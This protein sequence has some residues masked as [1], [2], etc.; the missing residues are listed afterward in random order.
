LKRMILAD[1]KMGRGFALM[2]PHGDLSEELLNLVPSSR[3]NDVLYFDPASANDPV[4]FNMLAKVPE[5]RRHLLVSGIVT[6]LKGIWGDSWGPR[7]QMILSQAL[8]ALTEVENVSL[9]SV[10]RMLVDDGY[11][12]WVVKQVRDVAVRQFW[13]REW[14]MWDP[15]FRAEAA[16]PVL[17]KLNALTLNPC[18]RLSLGQVR[19]AFDPRWLMDHGKIFIANLSR[20]RLGP[21]PS[22]LIGSLLVAAFGM[23]AMSRA[24]VPPEQRRDVT[25]YV[26]EF[27]TFSTD[28]F[29]PF[30]SEL[31]K[32]SAAMV[33]ACQHFSQIRLEVLDSVLG[34]VGTTISFRVG[35]R[36][37]QTLSRQFNNVFAPDAFTGLG[38][39]EIA[40]K[41]L[42]G[43]RQ[44]QPFLGRTLPDDHTL[45]GKGDSIRRHCCQRYGTPR[46]VVENKIERWMR[47]KELPDL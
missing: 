43:G 47:G 37:A 9:L 20:G 1:M 40:V 13:M 33:L 36:D 31:R 41:T 16:S 19:S 10:S 27:S 23:A 25:I 8:A 21:E 35:E 38:N 30:L 15:R 29:G 2:D 44:R 39:F 26:D 18:L 7:M 5:H 45:H 4:G 46:S 24:D 3:V 28:L 22:N 17:N 12:H 34:N 32:N 6:S 11:R 42:D 14:T